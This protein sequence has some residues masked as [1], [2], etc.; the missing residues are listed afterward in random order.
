MS[1]PSTLHD[2]PSTSRQ[3]MQ[4][5]KE[6]ELVHMLTN[7]SEDEYSDGDIF[8]CSSESDGEGDLRETTPSIELQITPVALEVHEPS[9][10]PMPQAAPIAPQIAI[11]GSKK[12]RREP[13]DDSDWQDS[14][15]QPGIFHFDA[16]RSGL[17]TIMVTK[18]GEWI[19]FLQ[20]C[21]SRNDH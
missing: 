20:K 14:D 16:S 11:T 12:R 19:F 5:L 15:F 4:L 18:L 2:K 8:A 6:H 13:D 7:E 1:E 9:A 10:V 21:I 3:P 17:L